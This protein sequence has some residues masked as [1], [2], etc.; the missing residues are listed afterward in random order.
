[1]TH[2]IQSNRSVIERSIG[3][4]KDFQILSGGSCDSIVQKEKEL[5]A[6]LS[7]HNLIR[8]YRD[9]RFETIPEHAPCLPGA[10]IITPSEPKLPS[11][12]KE[13]SVADQDFPPHLATFHQDLTK[14]AKQMRQWLYDAS[15]DQIFSNRVAQRGVNL[16]NG[17]NV[18]QIA[19]HQRGDSVWIVRAE[20][21]ASM[22]GVSYI[23]YLE[24]TIGSNVF[25]AT[26][27]CLAGYVFHV[28]ARVFQT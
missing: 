25:K 3:E 2:I 8:M 1:M 15:R 17:G 21:G 6:A 9:G 4:L 7:L 16:V 19:V 5:D 12:P 22:K 13:V 11:I 18:L 24:L 14:H 23:L 20:V 27:E 28:G 26:C 10:H